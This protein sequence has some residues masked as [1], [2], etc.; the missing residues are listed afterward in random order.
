MKSSFVKCLEH[1]DEF[2][3]NSHVVRFCFTKSIHFFLHFLTS[4]IIDRGTFLACR[5][6]VIFFLRFSGERGQARGE[7]EV[8]S[9]RHTRWEGRVS[10]TSR[11]PRACPRS[12]EKR[13]KITPVLQ[14]S[15]F[16]P[17]FI[18]ISNK[19]DSRNVYIKYEDNAFLK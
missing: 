5:T 9:A 18:Q 13:N 12:P 14:A 7:R 16:T 2:R 3:V 17:Y 10:R 19:R 1:I 15:L 11:S 8:R 4:I 6:G